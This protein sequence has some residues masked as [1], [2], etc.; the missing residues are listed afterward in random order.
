M[1]D[2]LVSDC[3]ESSGCA[4]RPGVGDAL[5]W[6]W[7]VGAAAGAAAALLRAGFA[8]ACC[9]TGW[10]GAGI[11]SGAWPTDWMLDAASRVQTTG[12]VLPVVAVA[13]SAS[14]TTVAAASRNGAT[15]HGLTCRIDADA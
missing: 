11:A 10:G 13:V 4:D 6:G 15:R 8:G 12:L 9:G 14:R 1:D 3:C 2:S 7:C 5:C